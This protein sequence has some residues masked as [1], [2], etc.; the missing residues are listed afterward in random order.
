M[1]MNNNT[2]PAPKQEVSEPLKAFLSSLVNPGQRPAGERKKLKDE[3][4]EILSGTDEQ[5]KILLG[6]VRRAQQGD[7]RAFETIRDMLGERPAEGE[8]DSGAVT[9]QD[10]I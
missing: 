8:G 6:L 3:L 4:Q 10:D 1:Y 7:V 2:S 5:K 9:I